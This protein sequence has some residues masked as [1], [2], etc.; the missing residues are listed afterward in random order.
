MAQLIN[1]AMLVAMELIIYQMALL[2]LLPMKMASKY[3]TFTFTL[4]QMAIFLREIQMG[5]VFLN[6]QQAS[7]KKE[8]LKMA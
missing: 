4:L 5:M 7:A 3:L 1:G 2:P 8:N 6:S